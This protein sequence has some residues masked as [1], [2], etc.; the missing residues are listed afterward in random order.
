MRF[1]FQQIERPLTEIKQLFRTLWICALHSRVVLA[2]YNAWLVEQAIVDIRLPLHAH[3]YSIS[4]RCI[5]GLGSSGA[6]PGLEARKD[7]S[8][9][10]TVYALMAVV[11]VWVPRGYGLHSR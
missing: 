8:R 3:R 6:F 5:P 4:C 2:P 11:V 10:S 1:H 9:T 7:L